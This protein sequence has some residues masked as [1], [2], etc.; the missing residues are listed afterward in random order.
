MERAD[1]SSHGSEFV[2]LCAFGKFEHI[3]SL[4]PGVVVVGED[5]VHMRHRHLVHD[6]HRRI[7][8]LDAEDLKMGL[9]AFLNCGS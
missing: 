9:F 3:E 6:R 2:H 1:R 4:E 7:E 5:L 8:R